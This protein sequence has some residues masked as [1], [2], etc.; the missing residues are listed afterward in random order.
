MGHKVLV[1][2]HGPWAFPWYWD[3]LLFYNNNKKD[4]PTQTLQAVIIHQSC[5]SN[6]RPDSHIALDVVS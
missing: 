6:C 5:P 3:T 2:I 1:K 4:L